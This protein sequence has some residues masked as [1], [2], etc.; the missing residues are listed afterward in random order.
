MKDEVENMLMDMRDI[1]GVVQETIINLE[2]YGRNDHHVKLPI[3]LKEAQ[4]YLDDIK[5]RSKNI[6][7]S[8][9]TLKCANDQ[10]EF[11]SEE[12]NTTSQQKD[13]LESYLELRQTFNDRLDDLKALTH[14]TFRDAS[15]T[16]AFVTKNR[17]DF[18]K[19]KQK[20]NRI[21]E[22]SEEL[23][24]F[25]TMDI[26]AQSD[27]LMESLHDG[28][29]KMRIDNKDLVDLNNLIETTIAEREDELDQ[30]KRK[31]VPDA[32][33]HAEDLAR[34]SKIIVDHFQTSKDGARVAMLAGTAHK[35]ISDAI[36]AA[37]IAADEAY[38]AAVYS[39]KKLNPADP[40][41]ETLIEK[42]QDLSLESEAIQGDAEN[43]ISKIKGKLLSYLDE[44]CSKVRIA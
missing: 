8:H 31:T 13:R 15:E 16:E 41:E 25:L 23:Q 43:Q 33:A 18:E 5:F 19:L 28:I 40:E 10:L 17:K 20:A 4:M 24:K 3:A 11:W 9:E 30:I 42:G 7:K 39:N 12:F 26:I 44:V 35:N 22:D 14:R 1:T 37:R 38:N 27:S 36:E 21:T 2:N 32:R 29:A 34:R 6:P